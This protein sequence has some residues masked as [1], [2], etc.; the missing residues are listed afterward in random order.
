MLPIAACI[1][2]SDFLF[3][4]QPDVT[5]RACFDLWTEYYSRN[6]HAGLEHFIIT[7]ESRQAKH[8][9]IGALKACAS[10]SAVCVV[11]SY[12]DHRHVF[13]IPNGLHPLVKAF[14]AS[15]FLPNTARRLDH[16]HRLIGVC[17]S[18]LANA[19][20]FKLLSNALKSG[21]IFSVLYLLKRTA[22]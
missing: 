8:S 21:F 5:F 11:P 4:F 13:R 7:H 15:P 17:A 16:T 19:A 9:M 20:A 2:I 12:L 6:I 3:P 1:S 10:T 14:I 18:G 22:S